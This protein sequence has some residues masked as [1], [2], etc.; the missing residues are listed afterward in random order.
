MENHKKLEILS[1]NGIKVYPEH[2]SIGWKIEVD[3]NGKTKRYDKVVTEKEINNKDWNKNPIGI[4][5]D[6][7][8]KKLGYKIK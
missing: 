7:F 4:T 2:T 8:I 3:V 5:I 1:K 6:Y